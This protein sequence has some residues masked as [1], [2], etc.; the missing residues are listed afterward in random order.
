MILAG[1]I[2]PIEDLMEGSFLL[3]GFWLVMKF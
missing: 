3:I 2:D 1:E